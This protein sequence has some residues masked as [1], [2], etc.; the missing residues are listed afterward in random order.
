MVHL[1]YYVSRYIR[2]PRLAGVTGW[3]VGGGWMQCMDRSSKIRRKGQVKFH[4]NLSS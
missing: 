2:H 3:G 1:V 4:E